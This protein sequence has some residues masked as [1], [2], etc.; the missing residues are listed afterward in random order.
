MF[1]AENKSEQDKT[2]AL[3]LNQKRSNLHSAELISEKKVE[4]CY[5]LNLD[6]PQYLHGAEN[7]SA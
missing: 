6:Q 4:T 5:V 7:N 2:I 3:N 1:C